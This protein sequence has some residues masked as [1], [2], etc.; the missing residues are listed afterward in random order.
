MIS[1][2]IQYLL[3]AGTEKEDFTGWDEIDAPV[4]RAEKCWSL[5]LGGG[6]SLA[7]IRMKRGIFGK[8]RS[9]NALYHEGTLE[10]AGGDEDDLMISL[11]YD[12]RISV[13]SD[14]IKFVTYSNS[15]A[16][17]SR[18]SVD[19]KEFESGEPE[20]QENDDYNWSSFYN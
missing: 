9:V 7:R 2:R 20:S 3:Y 5:Y 14:T 6:Y 12:V 10:D 16:E 17:L 18:E 1:K 11:V 8:R 13:G 4:R 19:W 15:F